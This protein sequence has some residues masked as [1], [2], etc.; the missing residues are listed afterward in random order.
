MFESGVC[1]RAAGYGYA[2]PRLW[3]CFPQTMS[4]LPL[5]YGYASPRLCQCLPV[6]LSC[7]STGSHVTSR[8][9]NSE[10]SVSSHLDPPCKHLIHLIYGQQFTSVP[11]SREL[12]GFPMYIQR[13]GFIASPFGWQH[14]ISRFPNLLCASVILNYPPTVWFSHFELTPPPPPVGVAASDHK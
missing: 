13:H 11:M 9:K 5:G 14:W 4:M 6:P 7:G 10:A 2:S 8:G 12:P 3:L 1:S